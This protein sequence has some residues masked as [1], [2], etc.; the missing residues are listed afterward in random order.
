MALSVGVFKTNAQKLNVQKHPL[1]CLH[2]II[3]DYNSST[4]LE[5]YLVIFLAITKSPTKTIQNA[6]GFKVPL[7]NMETALL[8]S[9]T[10]DVLTVFLPTGD[11][12]KGFQE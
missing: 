9:E 5:R 10:Q 6:L 3:A 1:L 11:G 4:F 12:F 8:N 7:Q 2:H